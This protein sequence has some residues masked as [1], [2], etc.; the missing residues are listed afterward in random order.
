MP[1]PWLS[2]P[3]SLMLVVIPSASGSG[4]QGVPLARAGAIYVA[5]WNPHRDTVAFIAAK[6]HCPRGTRRLS[7]SRHGTPGPAGPVGPPGATGPAGAVGPAGPTGA[8]GAIGPVGPAGATGAIGPAG[9]TGA[10]GPAGPTGA[11]GPAGPAGNSGASLVA[12]TPVTSAVNAAVNTTV[13]ATASC[14]AGHVALGGG[15]LVTTTAAQKSRAVLTASYPS[16]A[17]TWTAVGVS[18]AAL[19]AG[20][21][22]TVTAYVLCSP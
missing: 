9:P 1:A 16:A 20:N 18:T 10:T 8:T 3:L 2:V 7:W 5:C 14:S 12:G 22:M 17:A 19:G 15:A 13:T 21:T 11:T 6:A 4:K